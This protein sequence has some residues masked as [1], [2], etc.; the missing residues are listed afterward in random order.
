MCALWHDFGVLNQDQYQK[1]TSLALAAAI[2]LASNSKLLTVEKI[3]DKQSSFIF[4]NTSD[5]AQTIDKFWK[6]ELPLDA[7]S[8]FETL[9][10]IKARLYQEGKV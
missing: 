5:L 1:T 9:R 2:Q 4:E 10:Y 8:Y 3:S 7:L 6:K